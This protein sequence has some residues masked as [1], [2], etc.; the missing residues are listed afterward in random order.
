MTTS[1]MMS[2]AATFLVLK[3]AVDQALRTSSPLTRLAHAFKAE[4]IDKKQLR[5]KKAEDENSYKYFVH[6][7]NWNDARW[8]S[9][10]GFGVINPN[11]GGPKEDF[12]RGFYTFKADTTGV[13]RATEKAKHAGS[14]GAFLFVLK[15][16]NS[17]WNELDVV[18]WQNP[19]DPD[20]LKVV[21]GFRHGSPGYESGLYSADVVGGWEANQWPAGSG[22][23]VA[24]PNGGFQYKFETLKSLEPTRL[25]RAYLIPVGPIVHE[26]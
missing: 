8:W 4:V 19:S 6:G 10:L 23:W 3:P 1:I 15:M 21:N 26:A 24:N 7:S 25:I 5:T 14:M 17:R 13:S 9:A 22:N 20:Y 2:L 16:E 18:E 11:L 12:G